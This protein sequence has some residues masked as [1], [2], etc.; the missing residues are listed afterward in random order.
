MRSCAEIFHSLPIVRDLTECQT[1]M[2]VATVTLSDPDE[3][4]AARAWCREKWQEERKRSRPV[5][6]S[7]CDGPGT[8]EFADE[9]HA[10]EFSLKFGQVG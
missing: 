9:T 2:P 10:F 3:F 7:R 8:F 5:E 6:G 4:A 1:F